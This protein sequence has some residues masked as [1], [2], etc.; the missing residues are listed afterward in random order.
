MADTLTPPDRMVELRE[1]ALIPLS[2]AFMLDQARTGIAGMDTR[3]S[4]LV[5]AINQANIA[6]LTRDPEARQRYGGL[7]SPAPDEERRPVSLSAIA[8]SLNLPYETVRRRTRRLEELGVCALTPQGPIVPESFLASPA[9]LQSVVVAHLRLHRFYQDVRAAGLME[10]LPPSRYPPEP[11]VPIRA[12]LRL[13]SD[14]LL[15]TTEL[16]MGLTGDVISGLALFGLLSAGDTLPPPVSLTA[17]LAR[18]IGMPHETVRRHLAELANL[19]WC[20]RA[21]RGFTVSE[22]ILA[23]PEMRALFRDNA[24]NLQRLFTAL[25]E[26]GLIEAWERLGLPGQPSPG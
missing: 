4:L 23:R 10:P 12:S 24:I 13:I 18:R 11:T 1:R 22:E 16:L 7:E 25:A 5:L 3:D 20:V 8:A 15:R 9:Y 26:R 2:G 6:P 14:Y 21:G 17:V 19:G